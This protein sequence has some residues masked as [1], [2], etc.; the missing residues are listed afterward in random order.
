M[1]SV[2]KP[3]RLSKVQRR[4]AAKAH[5]RQQRRR[6]TR[7]ARSAR[8]QLQHLHDLLPTAARSLLQALASAFTRPTALRWSF[9]LLA[10]LLTVGR[11]TVR[12]VL[13]TLGPLVPG[14][15]SSYQHLL[16]R[17]R[18]SGLHL[19]R[20]LAGWIVQHYQP[21]GCIRVAAD[22]TVEEHRGKK[23]FGKARHR[24]PVRSTHSYTAFRW[25]HKW[26]IVALLIRFPFSRR[27]WALPVLVALYRSEEDNAKAGRRHKTPAQLV[28]QLLK[29]LLH[30]F[31]DRQFV[32]CADGNFATHE[33][34][35]TASARRQRLTLVSRFYADANLYA[36]PPLPPPAGGK[37]PTGRPPK[38]GK[39]GAAPQQVVAHG[40][41][42]QRLTVTWYGGGQ[43]AV[44][45]VARQGHWY[46]AGHSLV[47][48]L[49]VFVHDLTGTHRDEYF[50][51][52]DPQMSAQEVIE[53]YTGR[54]N[55]ETTFEE[56]RAY[57]GLETTQGWCRQTVLRAAPCLF[58]LYSVVAVLYASLPARYAR[59]RVVDWPGKRDVTFSDAITAVRRWLWQEWVFVI[60]GHRAAFA[61]LP[62][63]F[64]ALLLYG[65]AP[66]T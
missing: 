43:R 38:K 50:F 62:P 56:L 59:V 4:R 51:S 58:G 61:K 25:G 33:L 13:R 39:K 57:L 31:P 26:V 54:W 46:E 1:A 15:L 24:D 40:A 66:A 27:L 55:I 19:A 47:P 22:D 5:R 41:K 52:T 8:R 2:A 53:T 11:H 6:Q 35:R 65:L 16:S 28:R 20:L 45:V 37:K 17:G 3:Q 30:W 64:R 29:V 63:S 12:N 23:V 10:T 36:P 42:R 49:W 14:S 60:P 9:L 21:Q 18:W 34:A 7:K 48:V 32:C 44:E